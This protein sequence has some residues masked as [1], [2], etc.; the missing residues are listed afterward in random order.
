M[1]KPTQTTEWAS[2]ASYVEPTAGKKIVGFAPAERP[3]AQYLDWLFFTIE[4]WLAWLDTITAP[5]SGAEALSMS[6]AGVLAAD[7]AHGDRKLI[8]SPLDFNVEDDGGETWTKTYIEMRPGTTINVGE[9]YLLS[10]PLR[11]RVGDRIR[12]IVIYA[13]NMAQDHL[14]ELVSVARV[15]GAVTVVDSVS[16]NGPE[17]TI[18]A[19]DH[20]VLED[21]SYVLRIGHTI[22]GTPDDIQIQYVEVTYDRP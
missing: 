1:A 11:M 10:C 16:D 17:V 3:P 22:A 14:F 9:T 8:L 18:A 12:Q 4:L 5:A 20:T 2:D 7:G 19:T 13:A 6:S 15:T 21:S